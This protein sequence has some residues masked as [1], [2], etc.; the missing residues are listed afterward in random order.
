VTPLWVY[1]PLL[2]WQDI[3]RWALEGGIKKM[4]PPDQLHLTLATVREP[5]DW[6]DL[7]LQDNELTIP[8]GFKSVQILG[9]T[10]KA[11]TFGHPDIKTRHEELLAR[12]PQMDHP[13][14]RPHV[15][16]FRGGKLP[17]HGYLGELVFGPEKAT[18]FSEEKGRNI[19]HVKLADYRSELDQADAA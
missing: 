8:A 7:P 6:S 15:S 12:F 18:E 2:N 11:L 1:R 19:K 13:L 3:Y 10:V 16:L 17:Q 14:L 9:W 4:M 5:V